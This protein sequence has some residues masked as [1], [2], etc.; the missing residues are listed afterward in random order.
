MRR[1]AVGMAVFIHLARRLSSP[2][3]YNPYP[4]AILPSNISS[5]LARV[6]GE[7]TGTFNSSVRR[8]Q[9]PSMTNPFKVSRVG[10]EYPVSP[11][12]W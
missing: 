7:I 2:P 4:P 1:I 6:K 9:A 5:E 10:S 12:S 3:V 11:L 8:W